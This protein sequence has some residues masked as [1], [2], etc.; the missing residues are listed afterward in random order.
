MGDVKTSPIAVPPIAVPSNTSSLP[1]DITQRSQIPEV[2][3]VTDRTQL[4]TDQLAGPVPSTSIASPL[5][6]QQTQVDID[7]LSEKTGRGFEARGAIVQRM[8]DSDDEIF[9]AP[10]P[11]TARKMKEP[12]VVSK[13]QFFPRSILASVTPA[14]PKEL[15]ATKSQKKRRHTRLCRAMNRYKFMPS[16]PVPSKRY[17]KN[18]Q[19]FLKK[20][21]EYKVKKMIMECRCAERRFPWFDD[22]TYRLARAFRF[23]CRLIHLVCCP[24]FPPSFFHKLAFWPPP[25]EYFFFIN[26]DKTKKK[27]EA[28]Q[29]ATLKI[30]RASREAMT[31]N[32]NCYRFGFEHECFSEIEGVECFI[33]RTKFDSYLACAFIKPANPNPRYTLIFSHP[34]GSDISDHLSGNELSCYCSIN[35]LFLGIPSLQDTAAF[36]NCNIVAYDYSGYGISS[37]RHNERNLYA[38]IEAVYQHIRTE[39]NIPDESIILWGSS[40]GTAATVDLAVKLESIAGV[41]LFAPPTSIVRALCWKRFCFCC[42]KRQPCRSPDWKCRMD[43]FNTIKKIRH[44]QS[45]LLIIHGKD[46]DIIPI[47]HG[48]ALHIASKTKVLP[49]WIDGVGHNNIENSSQLW[50]RVRYFIRCEAR[51]PAVKTAIE[52]GEIK[53]IAIP[54]KPSKLKKRKTVDT[55]SPKMS[56]RSKR[57]KKRAETSGTLSRGPFSSNAATTEFSATDLNEPKLNRNTKK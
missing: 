15:A 27:A 56:V 7:D 5:V 49:L 43:K 44:V 10:S 8:S 47:E 46:D 25:R 45:P 6:A 36:L 51:P 39:R 57:W 35:H 37:G 26:E 3:P 52:R 24:P 4:E 40:I 13:H 54:E 55:E 32:S 21:D 41:I 31:S 16:E 34:N 1:V 11:K 33:V 22:C 20:V 38:D 19:R 17:H 28:A 14:A 9:N 30:R 23:L 48:E 18:D 29:T 50:K 12:Q 53:E 2:N 42:R